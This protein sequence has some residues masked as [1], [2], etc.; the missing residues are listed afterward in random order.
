MAQRLLIETN[1]DLLGFVVVDYPR[2]FREMVTDAVA[3]E[4]ASERAGLADNMART[5]LSTAR[6]IKHEAATREEFVTRLEIGIDLL[7]R[8]LESGT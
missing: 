7:M 2:R 4:T 8:A 1:P 6:G 3:A 5:L